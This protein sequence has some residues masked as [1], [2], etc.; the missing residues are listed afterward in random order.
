LK[1]ALKT[2][3]ILEMTKMNVL[4]LSLHKAEMTNYIIVAKD[5]PLINKSKRGFK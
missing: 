1:Y 4:L 3:Y 2:G 5:K